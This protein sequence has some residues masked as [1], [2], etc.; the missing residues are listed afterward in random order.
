[1]HNG[2]PFSLHVRAEEDGCAEDALK[3]SHQPSVLCPPLL[4]AEGIE[5]LRRASELN[6][7]ALLADCQCGEEYW[8]EP[9]LAPRETV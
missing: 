3:R 4:H 1:M 5:H 2:G 9:V 7:L 6:R 8:N